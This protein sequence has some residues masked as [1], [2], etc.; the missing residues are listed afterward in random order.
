MIDP[1]DRICE[2]VNILEIFFRSLRI[3]VA[4][5]NWRGMS[6]HLPGPDNVIAEEPET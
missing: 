1:H 3:G 2:A 6:P 4:L 5:L